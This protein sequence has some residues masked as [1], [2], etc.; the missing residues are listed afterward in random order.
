MLQQIPFV[1]VWYKWLLVLALEK[2]A[3]TEKMGCVSGHKS[4]HHISRIVYPQIDS[5]KAHQGSQEE[6]YQ[7]KP[8]N[9]GR[10]HKS[11]GK[12]GTGMSGG[13]GVQ[14]SGRLP[15]NYVFKC[16][17]GSGSVNQYFHQEDYSLAADE[18][19]CY[20]DPRIH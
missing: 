20:T 17:K 6:K 18:S 10:Q 1:G 12:G 7:A 5:G 3:G 4:D 15:D 14:V 19:R 13:E 8:R 2:D 16:F 9:N 11:Q